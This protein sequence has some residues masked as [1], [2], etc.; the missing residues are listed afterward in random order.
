MGRSESLQRLR[1]FH[2][3]CRYWRLYVTHWLS[4]LRTAQSTFFVISFVL[5]VN[6]DFD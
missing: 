6:F 1:D 2:L 3:H 4:F 5:T